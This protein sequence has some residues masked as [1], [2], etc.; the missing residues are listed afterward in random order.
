MAGVTEYLHFYFYFIVIHVNLNSQIWLVAT[1]LN[2]TG[3]Q[4]PPVGEVQCG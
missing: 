1:V 3:L 4:N 2:S